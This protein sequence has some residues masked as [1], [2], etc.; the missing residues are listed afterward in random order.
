MVLF[1]CFN[2]CCVLIFPM[3]TDNIYNFSLTAFTY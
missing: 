2:L 1:E 3:E